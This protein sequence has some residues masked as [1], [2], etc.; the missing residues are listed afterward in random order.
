M[1]DWLRRA[2]ALAPHIKN[3][4][5]PSVTDLEVPFRMELAILFKH[6]TKCPTSVAAYNEVLQ[7]RKDFPDVPVFL[8]LVREERPLAV[9][10][11][12][13]T[14]IAHASP[15][16]LVLRKGIVQSVISHDQI[17][18]DELADLVASQLQAQVNA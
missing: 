6:S 12:E 18:A 15:Q 13:R 4:Q 7:Y 11:S 9:E 10:I 1:F 8:I 16:I 2:T 3:G 5:I 17:T 14:G